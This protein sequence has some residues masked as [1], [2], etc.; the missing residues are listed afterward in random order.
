MAF[1]DICDTKNAWRLQVNK[2]CDLS[3]VNLYTEL[4][5]Q[6]VHRALSPPSLVHKYQHALALLC[7]QGQNG[8]DELLSQARAVRYR[9]HD[10]AEC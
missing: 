10:N 2:R 8:V 1:V 9:K 4:L 5:R 6:M 3:A 7:H